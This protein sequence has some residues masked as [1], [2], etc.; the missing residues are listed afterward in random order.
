MAKILS[1]FSLKIVRR[2]CRAPCI[3]FTLGLF[4]L[5]LVPIFRLIRNLHIFYQFSEFLKVGGWN[6]RASQYCKPIKSDFKI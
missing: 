1:R 4:I 2:Q 3:N 5:A 6:E